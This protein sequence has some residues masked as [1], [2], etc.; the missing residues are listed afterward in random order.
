MFLL[1]LGRNSILKLLLEENLTGDESDLD[2][3]PFDYHQFWRYR[4][5]ITVS[6]LRCSLQE[7]LATEGKST[8]QMLQK[9]L[10]KVSFFNCVNISLSCKDHYVSISSV[11]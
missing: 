8:C 10:D 7:F 11:A 5:P 1:V 4:I 9:F 3:H 6:H 2:Q